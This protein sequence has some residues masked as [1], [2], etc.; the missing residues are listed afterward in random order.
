[1]DARDNPMFEAANKGVVFEGITCGKAELLTRVPVFAP[2]SS[3]SCLSPGSLLVMKVSKAARCQH[4][5]SP[6]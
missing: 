6:P 1:M 4:P 3:I 5:T 2:D